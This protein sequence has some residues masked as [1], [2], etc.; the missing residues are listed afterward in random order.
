MYNKNY[1]VYIFL[2]G[3]LF[4]CP[5]LIFAKNF[6]EQDISK[7]LD[8]LKDFSCNFIQ[9]NPDGTVSEGSLIYSK[10]KIRINYITPSKIT[11]I[12]KKN[13]AMYYNEDL[14]ELHYFNPNKTAF[15]IF[16]SFFNLNKMPKD[17]YNITSNNNVINIEVKKI[18][19]D[20]ISEFDIVFQNN[21]IELK[22]IHWSGVDGESTFSIFNLNSGIIINKKTF[23]MVNPIINN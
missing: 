17:T 8:S 6:I 10:N 18:E 7:Y 1:L 3:F 15:N 9:A 14:M 12:A 21:P 11:F 13:K 2:A 22:K 20:E 5:Q 16:K 23:S 4:I 19:V